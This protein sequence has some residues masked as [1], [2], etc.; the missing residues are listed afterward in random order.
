MM[1]LMVS[2]KEGGSY[3]LTNKRVDLLIQG[4]KKDKDNM[5]QMWKVLLLKEISA[6]ST[7]TFLVVLDK[8][9]NYKS[10]VYCDPQFCYLVEKK[11]LIIYYVMN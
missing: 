3:V 8:M 5:I 1:Q 6:P 2:K 7:I 4:T 10:K 11:S 9:T